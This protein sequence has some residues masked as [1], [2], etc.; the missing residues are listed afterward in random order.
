MAL[1]ASASTVV[2]NVTWDGLKPVAAGLAAGIAGALLAGRWLQ[3]QLYE[4]GPRDPLAI[5]SVAVL[6][7]IVAAA[8]ALVPAWRAS[9]IDPSRA[10]HD[11]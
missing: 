3:G 6:M 4:V 7:L 2:R 11:A 9:S 1:G 5:A 8:A 10:L